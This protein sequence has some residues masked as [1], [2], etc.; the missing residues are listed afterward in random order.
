V[1]TPLAEQKAALRARIRAARAQRTTEERAHAGAAVRSVVLGLPEVA[2]AAVVAAYADSSG[3]PPTGAL[4]A[5]LADQHK[6]VLLPVQTADGDLDWAPHTG[7][8]RRG[9]HGIDE[10]TTDRTGA[11]GITRADVIVVPALAVDRAGNRLGQ[12]G[13]GYDRALRRVRPEAL[14]VAVVYPDELLAELPV[15]PHDV[16]VHAAATSEGVVRLGTA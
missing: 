13:G 8:L 7:Q 6:Q 1:S 5:A 9:P 3:E 15:E 2:A 10:P 11:E 16:R 4:L 14:I 12:G